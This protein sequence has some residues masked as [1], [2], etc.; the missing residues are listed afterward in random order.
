MV[1][2]LLLLMYLKILGHVVCVVPCKTQKTTDF[3]TADVILNETEVKENLEK[4]TKRGI[5]ECVI[6]VEAKSAKGILH[7][8]S[9]CFH[10]DTLFYEYKNKDVKRSNL[11]I[12]RV[13]RCPAK[14]D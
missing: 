12:F 3:V 13:S 6:E 9:F 5:D 1:I 10:Q 11:F 8:F 4:Y 2:D 14:Q 7:F